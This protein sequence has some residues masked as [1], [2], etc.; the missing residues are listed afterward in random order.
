MIIDP[1][2]QAEWWMF[3]ATMEW[4][5][6]RWAAY[7]PPWQLGQAPSGHHGY[8]FMSEVEHG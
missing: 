6:H 1:T 8:G 4:G 3:L 2:T 5:Y 7:D